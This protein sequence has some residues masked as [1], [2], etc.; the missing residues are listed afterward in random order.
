MKWVTPE[1]IKV[2]RVACPWLVNESRTKQQRV[3][4]GLLAKR[5][6]WTVLTV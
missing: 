4:F 3:G 6:A 2:E 1:R 5:R